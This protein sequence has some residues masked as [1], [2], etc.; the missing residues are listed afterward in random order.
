MSKSWWGDDDFKL[1]LLWEF[2]TNMS[3]W[4]KLSVGIS[5]GDCSVEENDPR[6]LGIKSI[7]FGEGFNI[8]ED[9]F[10]IFIPFF[11]EK[12]EFWR[13]KKDFEGNNSAEI[14]DYTS[15]LF[16]EWIEL[17]IVVF[18]DKN[19]KRSPKVRIFV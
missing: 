6:R 16:A 15:K 9:Y 17:T 10:S 4:P 14:I 19:V 3:T 12:A 18:R 5:I 11:I 2:W 13:S 7:L 1:L 8:V